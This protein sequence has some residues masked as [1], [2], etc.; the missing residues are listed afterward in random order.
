MSATLGDTAFFED[1]LTKLNGRQ[2]VSVVSKDRPVPLD[3][4]F[5]DT[6]LPATVESLVQQGKSPVYVV[7]FTQ[8][9][10]AQSAQNFTSFNFCS[11]E[12]KS[13]LA[14]ALE[15]FV[16][17]SPYGADIKRWLK[18]G[19][20]LHHAGLLPKYRILTER[21][22]QQGLLKIIC[23]TDTL[24]VGINVPIRTVLLTKLCKYDGQKTAILSARD[25]HQIT[26]RA[27]R[28]GFDE[29]GWVVAQAPE[30][31]IE[32]AQREQKRVRDGKKV[33]KRKPP[34]KNFVPWDNATF[35]RL[36]AASPERLVSRF[37]VSHGMLLNVLSRPTDGCVAM[38]DIIRRCHDTA[39]LKAGHTARAWQLLRSL[40]NRHIVEFI[41]TTSR[42]A[43]LRVNVNLQDDFSMDQTLS[44][45]L[46]E[47]VSLLD[48]QAD[49]Y[50]LRLLT[51]IESILENPDFILRKQLDRI[52]SQKMNEMKMDGVPFEQRIEELDKL[53]YPKPDRDF[54]YSTFND[55][56]DRHPWVGQE[57]IRIKSIVREMFE[58]FSSFNDYI[59]SYEL[60]R[61]EGLLLRHI[62]G[63]YGVLAQTVPDAIKTDAVK[64]MELYLG[65]MIRQVDSSLLEEWEKM[66]N[67]SYQAIQSAEIRPP[68]ADQQ[69][70]TR[71]VKAFTA[72][73]RTHIFA[74][75]SAFS[76]KDFEAALPIASMGAAPEDG[77]GLSSVSAQGETSPWT[78]RRLES[79][80]D[81][82]HSDHGAICLD[83][84]ARNLRHTY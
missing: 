73:I 78:A 35:N 4:S 64:E 75:L 70:I 2:T 41:P 81:D 14:T 11:K 16:F 24:G 5:A 26:G 53:E 19:I 69:D 43:K 47:T 76:K 1:E 65:T 30:Y 44:L 36:I 31:V 20:G 18:Q 37:Q 72:L 46:L 63:V 51:L 82:F 77:A 27:G 28:K 54:I 74:F 10:A 80:W 32:N 79:A 57:N 48:T 15:G 21:L 17:N 13:R 40:V 25:F 33:V 60:Q 61:A 6:L 29:C 8:L 52:K 38:R 56:V 83:P 9:D 23:G 39:K 49:D 59:R 50:P 7:H 84:N 66:R 58:T 62:N 45:Y 3:Y 22:A 34:D 12:E 71:D 55:F 42:G 68:G 67:P